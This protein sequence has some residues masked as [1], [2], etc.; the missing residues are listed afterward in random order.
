MHWFWLVRAFLDLSSLFLCL[1]PYPQAVRGDLTL[2]IQQRQQS[3]CS[4]FHQRNIAA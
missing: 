3:A 2:L 4:R 1:A